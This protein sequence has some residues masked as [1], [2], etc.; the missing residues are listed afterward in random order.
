MALGDSRVRAVFLDKDGTLVE[1]I[2]YN[3]DPERVVLTGGAED[4]LRLL[5]HAGYRIFV[6]SNQSGVARGYF[7]EAALL[8]VR[9]RLGTLLAELGVPL[10]GFFYC[11]H[12]PDG[13]ISRYAIDC[14]CRKPSPGLLYR[15]AEEHRIDLAASWVIGDILDD[16]EAGA[17]AGCHTILVD[18]GSET[19]WRLADYR[20]PDLVARDLRQAADAILKRVTPPA[21]PMAA[22]GAA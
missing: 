16:V 10:A 17:R 4:G 13:A 3:V 9:D 2:P 8:N 14:A 21:R 7:P 19:E 22:L 15:A 20:V 12:H 5:H 18:Q 6:V 11:P 1:N